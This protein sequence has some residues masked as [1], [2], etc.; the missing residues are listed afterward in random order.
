[1][2]KSIY[3]I[4]PQEAAPYFFSSE[5]LSAANIGRFPIVADLA[6]PTVAALV[7]EGWSIAICDERR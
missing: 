7:P 6:T 3:I 4:N 1:M 5:V 2:P